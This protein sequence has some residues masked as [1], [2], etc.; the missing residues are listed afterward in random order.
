MEGCGVRVPTTGRTFRKA[1]SVRS[2]RQRSCARVTAGTR[3]LD[4][5]CGAG[6]AA[7]I[8]AAR[9]AQVFGI[10]AAEA[11][12][13]IAR[14]RTPNGDFRQGDLEDLPFD[15]RSFDVVTGFNSLQYAGN[16]GVALGEARRLTKPDGI[17]VVMTWGDPDD[18]E[19]AS[20]VV[21]L[22]PLM[23]PPPPGAPGPFA[24]SDEAT[25]RKFATDAGLTP[26]DVFD[27]DNPL[28]YPDESTAIRGFNASGVTARAMESS[29][30][31]AVTERMPRRSRPSVSPTAVFASERRSAASWHNRNAASIE[32]DVRMRSTFKER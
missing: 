18:M 23:P 11:L 4:V 7:Q 25:L 26:V 2:T 13:E 15:D 6:R 28:V 31:R 14:R 21:A 27:V 9:G 22:H 17:V 10:D 3:Y 30:E 29:S 12:L 20:L 8:A 16:S 24:L 5:G 1:C 32:A 19:A